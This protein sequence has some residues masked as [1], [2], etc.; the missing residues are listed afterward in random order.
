MGSELERIHWRG[1]HVSGGV[2]LTGL[3]RVALARLIRSA[4]FAL[5][6]NDGC[7]G[8]G[9]VPSALTERSGVPTPFEFLMPFLNMSPGA[10]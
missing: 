2:I 1:K 3:Y 5:R 6:A 8:R 7:Y 9:F 10:I 4:S